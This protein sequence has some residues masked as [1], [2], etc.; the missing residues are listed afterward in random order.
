MSERTK[1]AENELPVD[2]TVQ[3]LLVDDRPENLFVL[4]TVLNDPG[5]RCITAES[6]RDALSTLLHDQDFAGIL[7]DVQ[8]PEMDGFEVAR[9]I[10]SSRRTR[11]IPIIFITAAHTSI[12]DALKGY[13]LDAIDYL[14]KPFDE[15]ILRAKVRQLAERHRKAR[16]ARRQEVD[17]LHEIGIQQEPD[18]VPNGVIENGQGDRLVV[19][20]ARLLTQ[21]VDEMA[22]KI[23]A[24]HGEPLRE[25]VR[26]LGQQDATPHDLI[27][28]HLRTLQRLETMQKRFPQSAYVEEG[29]MLLLEMMG[30]LALH[31]RGRAV[32]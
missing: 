32:D 1:P 15:Q 6:G 17:H 7:L 12:Q 3:L 9:L 27:E 8:M 26:E 11:E 5:Y 2:E 18:T 14:T 23:E 16:R 21:V 30:E 28:L 4:T 19:G 29:R 20:Y 31:Y 25:L 13:S 24:R 22:Y 10:R